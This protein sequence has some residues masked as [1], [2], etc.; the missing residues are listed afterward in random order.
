MADARAGRGAELEER[1][2]AEA[3]LVACARG[4][5]ERRAARGPRRKTSRSPAWC[6]PSS[7]RPM[8]MQTLSATVGALRDAIGRCRLSQCE[9]PSRFAAKLRIL[10]RARAS[11]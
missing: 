8:L 2:E 5:A 10:L 7:A 3:E 1:R 4:R 6:P 11:Q 9:P